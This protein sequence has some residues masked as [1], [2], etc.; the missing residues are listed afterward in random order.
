MYEP[1]IYKATEPSLNATTGEPE[2]ASAAIEV[3]VSASGCV[4]MCVGHGP[5]ADPAAS[6]GAHA[7]SAEDVPWS[8]RAF[9]RANGQVK[10]AVGGSDSLSGC[11][12]IVCS[13]QPD[14]TLKLANCGDIGVVAAKGSGNGR[15]RFGMQ[16]DWLIVRHCTYNEDECHRVQDKGAVITQQEY[17]KGK[18]SGPPRVFVENGHTR[19]GAGPGL[20]ATRSLGDRLGKTIGV[21]CEPEVCEYELAGASASSWKFIVIGSDLLWRAF[22]TDDVAAYV[23]KYLELK[24]PGDWHGVCQALA[25]AAQRKARQS[26]SKGSS[27]DD[28]A[29]VIVRWSRVPMSA[30][31][32]QQHEQNKFNEH[33]ND[34][35]QRKA[36]S[37]KESSSRLRWRY[38]SLFLGLGAATSTAA[39]FAALYAGRKGSSF[40]PRW[41]K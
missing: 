32:H 10:A 34:N 36:A 40:A 14:G 7:L 26:A 13:V 19:N 6:A 38:W 4:C 29:V 30:S 8:K 17:A 24:A 22:S 18:A 3:C 1:E 28:C 31:T 25:R 21:S 39:L 37:Q 20:L 35:R 33:S 11:S 5:L 9:E 27:V 16:G 12:A 23:S 41:R 2:R 15:G